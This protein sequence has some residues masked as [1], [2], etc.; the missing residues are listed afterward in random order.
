M[1][2]RTPRP[3]KAPVGPFARLVEALRRRRVRFVVIGVSG[4]NFYASDAALAF[5]TEDHDLFLPA[6]ARNELRAWQACTEAGF[7]LWLGDE[8]LD[9][10]RDLELARQIVRRRALVR[11]TPDDGP[12]VDLTLVMAGFTFPPVYAGRR[13]FLVDGVRIDVARLHDIVASKAAAGRPKDRLFLATHEQALADLLVGGRPRRARPP[14][15]VRRR[16]KSP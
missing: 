11:A 2:D 15:K 3:L 8:P 14:G 7:D 13:P 12:T 4:A 1:A 9:S 16:K 6:D 10:P 5:H